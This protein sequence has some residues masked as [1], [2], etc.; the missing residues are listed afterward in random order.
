MNRGFSIDKK[1]LRVNAGLS[2]A[3]LAKLSGL[4]P[5]MISLLEKRAR[6]PSLKTAIAISSALN[7]SLDVYAGI[8][9]YPTNEYTARVEITKLKQKI[10]KAKDA[11]K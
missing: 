3:E 7:I 2:Q 9:E 10:Q 5:T 6:E 4:S 11:L 1:Q 8:H